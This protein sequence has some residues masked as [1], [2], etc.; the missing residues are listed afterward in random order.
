MPESQEQEYTIIFEPSGYRG[1]VTGGKTITEA[2]RQLG[3]DIEGICGEKATCGK[4]KV[5]IEKGFFE[6]YGV[7]SQME[8]LSPIREAEGDLLSPQEQYD[9]YRLA[10]QAR[11]HG[12]VVVF[13]PE[14]SRLGKQV[15]RKAARQIA[16]ELKPAIRK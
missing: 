10:C 4:C 16:I 15:V 3:M 11:I 1:R 6:K 13:V 2:S 5:R 12:D 7:E 9:G 8:S 14:E